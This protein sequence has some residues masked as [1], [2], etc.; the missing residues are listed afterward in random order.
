MVFSSVLF[1]FVFLPAVLLIHAIAP[2]SWRNAVLLIASLCFY[3][4]GEGIFILIMLAS[5]SMNYGFAMM[6]ER[7]SDS[8]RR[9][10][11]I[12]A[13]IA[14]LLLLGVFKYFNF[15]VENI[16]AFAGS[17][18][19]PWLVVEQIHLPIGISFFT[20]Q[21]MSY[22]IE[23][24]RRVSPAQ[25]N[26]LNVGLY[27]A[28]FP[29]LI[30]GPI[31][32]YRDIASQ[33][34]N[35]VVKYGDF[36]SG[37]E[38]FVIGLGKKVLLANPLGEVADE[39][40]GLPPDSITT[41]VAWAGLACYTLQIYFDF[42]GYSDM[43]IGLG[44]MFGFKFL[45]NFNFP[46]IS[47]SIQEFWRR[48]HISLSNWFRDFLYIPLGGNRLGTSRTYLN[49]LIVFLLCGL[50][51][52]ASWNFIAWGALH[53]FFLVIERIG[54]LGWSSKLWRPLRHLYVLLVVM[55]G[56]VFF[57]VETLPGAIDF[58]E[59]LA[60]SNPI[61]QFEFDVFFNLE[62]LAVFFLAVLFSM[63]VLSGVK[64]LL[65][66]V[67]PSLLLDQSNAAQVSLYFC[68]LIALTSVL[69]LSSVHLMA[70]SHNPFIYF[71]F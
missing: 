1:L 58:L 59:V 69:V 46:Y 10:W 9:T 47:Q 52:G 70:G 14:N 29:Q 68:K 20:F 48:W 11:V 5:I 67:S 53:G 16:N 23:V 36:S 57:R 66:R 51:H 15:I 32:R 42:S 63:P 3:A 54:W 34:T 39:I 8:S 17:S 38:R 13:V 2:N 61:A 26:P 19:V 50:W 65:V 71:R 7:A 24:Y 64:I 4:W 62:R 49:L 44:R 22:V 56:W 45:E 41:T 18:T 12:L 31:V 60:G 35:R 37:I 30:A 27:I 33:L 6:L 55:L 21:A 40:F 43:A 28:L 25:T